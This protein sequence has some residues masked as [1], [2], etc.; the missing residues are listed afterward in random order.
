MITFNEYIIE[1]GGENKLPA[2]LD[3]M[4]PW[5]NQSFKDR[6]ISRYKY[7]EIGMEVQDENGAIVKSMLD[8]YSHY[9]EMTLQECVSLYNKK[10]S[11]QIAHINNLYERTIKEETK[12]T[13]YI[14]PLN[15]NTGDDSKLKV[16]GVGKTEKTKSFNWLA[17]NAKV[18]EEIGKLTILYEKALEYC[19]IIFYGEY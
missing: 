6:F 18:M 17:S 7:R 3:M 1:I 13:A 10:I 15:A 9:L 8:R 2:E 16:A 14:N 11:D 5:E 4:E 12:D 19:E